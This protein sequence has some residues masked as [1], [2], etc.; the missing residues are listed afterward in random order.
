ME[1]AD[2]F[3]DAVHTRVV[4]DRERLVVGKS[5]VW[6]DEVGVEIDGLRKLED[7]L[8][9]KRHLDVGVSVVEVDRGLKISAGDR[10]TDAGGEIFRDVALEI[11]KQ[12]EEFAVSRRECEARGIEVDD[13]GTGRC[14]GCYGRFEGGEY[15]LRR[16]HE[17][18][19]A[20]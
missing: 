7:V 2:R 8:V 16:R 14:Q 19:E 13:S 5:E 17:R 1:L 12:H 20:V 9:K 15:R 18:I 3:V 11:V 6:I 10:D 4:I